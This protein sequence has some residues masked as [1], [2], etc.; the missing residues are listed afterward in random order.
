VLTTQSEYTLEETLIAQFKGILNHRNTG[1]VF[2]RAKVLHDKFA[3]SVL[4]TPGAKGRLH[5][6]ELEAIVLA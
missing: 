1:N 2:E 6:D 4:H 3:L 5:Q